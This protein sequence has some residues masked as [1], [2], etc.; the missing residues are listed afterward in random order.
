MAIVSFF[1]NFASSKHTVNVLF[2]TLLKVLWQ[3][4]L[5]TLALAIVVIGAYAQH[6]LKGSV[7]DTDGNA[8]A[9]AKVS[10]NDAL[11]T[12]TAADGSFTFANLSP[13]HYQWRVS[14]IGYT[15]AQGVLHL[16]A[17]IDTLHIVLQALSL[18]LND[19]VVTAKQVQMGSKSIIDENAIRHI[20]PKSLGDLLQLVPG[21]LV[22]SP[23]LNAL[24]QAHI[25]EIS[26]NA[27]NALGTS[28]VVD[29]IPLSNDANLEVLNTNRYGTQADGNGLRVGEHTTAGRGTDLRTM[30]AGHIASLEVI[31]GIPSV[32][33]GNLTSGVIIVNTKATH[34]PWEIKLQADPN[35]KLAYVGKGFGL[36]KRGTATFSIDWAQSWADT[37]LHYKGYDRLTG[38]A[39]YS[40]QWRHLTADIK[41]AFYTSINQ[42]KRD[43]QMLDTQ[44][45]WKNK[46]RGA[47]L[48]ISGQYSNDVAFLSRISYKLSGQYAHQHNWMQTWIYN[49]DG[50]ITNTREPGLHVANFKRYGYRSTYTIDSKPINLYAQVV[51]HKYIQ[52]NTHNFTAFKIGVEY[53]YDGNVGQGLRYDI[54]A[55]P[56]AASTHRLRPRSYRSIPALS[57]LSGFVSDRLTMYVR[58]R[59][60][61][62][63]AGVRISHLFLNSKESGGRQ[64]ILV[65]EPRVN[66]SLELLKRQ[67]HTWLDELTLTGGYGLSNKMPT[68]AHLYPDVAYFDHVALARWSE[69]TNNQL[70]LVQTTIVH[71]TQNKQLSPAHA[72]KWELGFTFRR[73][74]VRGSLTYFYERHT[75]EFNFQTQP[76]WINYPYY[77]LPTGATLPRF[78][79]AT[80]Q[81]Y[82]TKDN[83]EHTAAPTIYTERT[84]WAMPSNSGRSQKHG[85]EYSF[86]FGEWRAL[87][88]SLNVSGAWFHIKRQSITP[89]YTN[90]GYDTRMPSAN[91]Y[92][93]V[94]PTGAGT[95][96]ER[97]STNMAFVTHIPAV[98][99]I[100]TTTLQM[101]WRESSKAIYE[102][103]HG[104]S[105]YYLKHYPDRNY[106]VVDPLGYYD[107]QGLWHVWTPADAN[108]P[109]LN[110]H[111]ARLQTYD[112]APEVAKPWAMLSLRL[113][114]ELGKTA[115]LSFIANNLTNTRKYRRYTTSNT[116]YQVYPPLY[117][118]VELKLKL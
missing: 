101:V 81:L 26:T 10:L 64:G 88:T 14:Y 77:T 103:E 89:S 29:G 9:M 11:T 99:L 18:Q 86:N 75:H 56:Q 27:N 3:R 2:Y 43:P 20:Q 111:M 39:G 47:R 6:N 12:T 31:R 96:S 107:A 55:P 37:R 85:I 110:A 74:Q 22:K 104:H 61:Q 72:R 68:L 28:L 84:S 23:N 15:P 34:T 80:Q 95:V 36:K 17:S 54:T 19:V 51:A 98:K 102:D 108:N 65:A 30:S 35:A 105:R 1:I 60:W 73:S 41:G 57:T 112:L 94:L 53:T 42:T 69:Q 45:A 93:V 116:Q 5:A 100:F 83:L 62:V 66:V 67:H 16:T 49:P 70:A 25:R 76:L 44:S 52:L 8:L 7:R 50:V 24:S 4:G 33:Y 46:H 97:I 115:D 78:D 71:D 117:F 91:A 87:R 90:V 114:K 40:R 79:T 58:E 63:E 21:N 13:G 82:Y 106:M 118:G 113:T 32:E 48:S 38:S 92:M 109:A 59:K